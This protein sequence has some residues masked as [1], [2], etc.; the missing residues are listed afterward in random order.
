MT[1]NLT[2]TDPLGLRITRKL[3]NVCMWDWDREPQN[4]QRQP[5][6]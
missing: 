1:L 4:L 5:T 2:I 6:R 3:N